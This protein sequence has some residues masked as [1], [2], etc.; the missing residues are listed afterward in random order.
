MEERSSDPQ[1]WM[2]WLEEIS[3]END[4]EEDQD[5]SDAETVADDDEN[6]EQ[7]I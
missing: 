4:Q 2:Q 3:G 7:E 1:V 5:L 6:D